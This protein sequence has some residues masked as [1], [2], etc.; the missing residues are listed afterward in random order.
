MGEFLMVDKETI[1]DRT[2]GLSGMPADLIEKLSLREIRDLV[3]YLESLKEKKET[4]H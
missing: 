4:G 1:L 3:A 2:K